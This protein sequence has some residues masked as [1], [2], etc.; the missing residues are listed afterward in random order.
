MVPFCPVNSIRTFFAFIDLGER[1]G[2]REGSFVV[3]L[4]YA[5]IG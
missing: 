3:P 2:E 1:E 4:I 5:L